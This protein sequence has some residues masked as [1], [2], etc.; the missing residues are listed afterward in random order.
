MVYRQHNKDTN[1]ISFEHIC[2]Y[3]GCHTNR[4]LSFNDKKIIIIIISHFF[5]H[6]MLYSLCIMS[7]ARLRQIKQ[8]PL[9][10]FGKKEMF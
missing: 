10:V 1:T 5:R 4:E 9:H 3:N 6:R 2:I 7:S 8:K